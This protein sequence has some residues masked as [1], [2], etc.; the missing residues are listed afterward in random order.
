MQPVD[1]HLLSH[2]ATISDHISQPKTLFMEGYYINT[3]GSGHYLYCPI[4]MYVFSRIIRFIT[5]I[6]F[7]KFHLVLKCI[8]LEC[9]CLEWSHFSIGQRNQ[10]ILCWTEEPTCFYW[11]EKP[12]CLYSTEE[13]TCPLLDIGTNMSFIGPRNQYIAIWSEIST[14]IYTIK[15]VININRYLHNFSVMQQ[16]M[17]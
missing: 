9:T 15:N 16:K 3:D 2:D 6:V 13:S 5:I 7:K 8:E 14:C 11:K 10:H 12:T 4:I 1:C 17:F